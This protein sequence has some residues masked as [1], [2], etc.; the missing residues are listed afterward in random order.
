[1][2]GLAG[3]YNGDESRVQTMLDAITHRGPDARGVVEHAG[4][5]HG[6]V[7]LALLDLSPASDQPF[8]YRGATLSYN[9]ELWNWRSLRQDLQDRG[10]D[11][12]TTGDTEVLA[13]L[14]DAEGL[15]GL[16]KIDGMFA[17][18]WASSDGQ[19]WLARDAFGK[20]PLY[21]CKTRNGFAWASERKA[22]ARDARPLP[23]PPGHALNLSTGVWLQWYRLPTPT[24]LPASEVLSQLREGVAQR[25]DADA[26]VCC[27]ISGGLDSGAILALAKEQHPDVTAYTAVFDPGANDLKAARRLCSELSVPLVEVPVD[28]TDQAVTEAIRAIEIPSKAQTEIAVLCLP[29]ARRIAADGFKACLSGEAA[30]ELFGGYGNFCIQASKDKRPA[31]IRQLRL[32]QLEK[33]SR[34]NFVRCN[35]VFMAHGVECRLPFMHQR[36]AESAIQL[37]L[38]QSPPQKRLL[39]Q[40]CKSVLPHWCVNRQKDTFQGGAGISAVLAKRIAS[41]IRYYNAEARRLFGYLPRG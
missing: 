13:V 15:A 4:M 8:R 7:R 20:V 26:P 9:G 12:T 17:F 19:R 39:K 40:A 11:F 1:M 5:I 22:F 2:C 41:P 37:D 6:H 3:I 29:L 10:Y 14:L 33:M 30:D 16:S 36:L 35:K 27:L 21:V 38:S 23:V 31:M 24:P 25:L 18:A 32:N 34:G 28:L